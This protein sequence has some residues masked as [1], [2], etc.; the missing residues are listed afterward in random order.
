[1]STCITHNHQL[2]HVQS[3]F[4]KL[5]GHFTINHQQKIIEKIT[6]GITSKINNPNNYYTG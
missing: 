6:I 3:L 5:I 4:I 2:S 1:M